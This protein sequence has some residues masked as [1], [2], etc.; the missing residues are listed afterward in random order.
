MLDPA[1]AAFPHEHTCHRDLPVLLNDYF[2]L[3][4]EYFQPNGQKKQAYCIQFK[5]STA[6]INSN[7][8]IACFNVRNNK[9]VAIWRQVPSITYAAAGPR[10]VNFS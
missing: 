3:P 10:K 5:L 8:V 2:C 7:V 6:Q 4:T 1:I 9:Q